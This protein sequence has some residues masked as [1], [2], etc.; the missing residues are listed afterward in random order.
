MPYNGSYG[1]D[2]Y[3]CKSMENQAVMQLIYQGLFTLTPA[4]DA[5]AGTL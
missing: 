4:Y 5:R 2:P 3:S 1:W